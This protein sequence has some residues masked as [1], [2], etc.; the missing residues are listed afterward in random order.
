M[1]LTLFFFVMSFKLN[2]WIPLIAGVLLLSCTKQGQEGTAEDANVKALIVSETRTT[3]D[4]STGAVERKYFF[5]YVYRFDDS[6]LLES[7]YFE[8]E[9]AIS[10]GWQYYHYGENLIIEHY[11]Y[12]DTHSSDEIIY[13]DKD[14]RATEIGL[15]FVEDQ[16]DACVY[17]MFYDAQGRLS[18]Y[19]TKSRVFDGKLILQRD[20]IEW[21]DRDRIVKVTTTLSP[22]DE[23]ETETASV[24]E[25]TDYP[26]PLINGRYSFWSA[27]PAGKMSAK[28]LLQKHCAYLRKRA[29]ESNGNECEYDYSFDS[30]GRIVRSYS[31]YHDNRIGKDTYY[32][33]NHIYITSDNE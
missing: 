26:N 30:K 33:C 25:Y 13:L 5:V 15:R 4:R 12:E 29:L 2:R 9:G 3:I 23:P 22:P 31:I 7:Q 1:L 27:G 11:G 16:D 8:V 10:H 6:G 18:R 19:E 14:G 24:Y 28:G 20:D 17:T 21:D 32:E